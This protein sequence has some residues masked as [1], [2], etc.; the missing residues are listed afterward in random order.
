VIFPYKHIHTH[1]IYLCTIPLFCS[2]DLGPGP[3]VRGHRYALGASPVLGT[4]VLGGQWPQWAWRVVT[5]WVDFSCS[6]IGCD[7]GCGYWLFNQPAIPISWRPCEFT[8]YPLPTLLLW[9]WGLSP[10]PHT[11]WASTVY[12]ATPNPYHSYSPCICVLPVQRLNE[13]DSTGHSVP[14]A[15]VQGRHLLCFLA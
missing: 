8:T 11:G 6:L 14:L 2:C 4:S 3:P 7:S 9:C 13:S 15:Q 5:H 1:S 12:W 10:E